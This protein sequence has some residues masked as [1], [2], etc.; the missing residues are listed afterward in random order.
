MAVMAVSPMG[1][2]LVV[3]V[4]VPA[5]RGFAAQPLIVSDAAVNSTVPPGFATAGEVTVA[6]NVT[7][8]ES[9]AGL[10]LDAIAVVLDAGETVC[11][12]AVAPLAV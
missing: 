1:R 9:T 6:V 8:W 10:A 2:V 7:G 5:L 3:Q 4:A 12:I 11:E